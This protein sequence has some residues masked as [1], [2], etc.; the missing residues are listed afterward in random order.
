MKRRVWIIVALLLVVLVAGISFSQ[1]GQPGKPTLVFNLNHEQPTPAEAI[2]YGNE[3]GIVTESD[4]TTT[5]SMVMLKGAPYY[6][7]INPTPTEALPKVSAKQR[8][9]SNLKNLAYSYVRQMEARGESMAAMTDTMVAI[10]EASNLVKQVTDKTPGCFMVEWVDNG[11]EEVLVTP[12]LGRPT[13]KDRVEQEAANLREHIAEGCL[14]VVS[15]DGPQ[16]ILPN[17]VTR[18]KAEIAAAQNGTWQNGILSPKIVEELRQ[19]LKIRNL[20]QED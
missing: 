16:I 14:I 11:F 13:L 19:P 17:Q 4:V 12:T 9:V 8:S 6:P 7:W 2:A 10:Y 1:P 15:S 20:Q 3:L 5:D 18:V